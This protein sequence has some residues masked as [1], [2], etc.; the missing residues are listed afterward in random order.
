MKLYLWNIV[1]AADRLLNA[2]FGGTD[3]EYMSSRVYRYK[4]T[5]TA[6][7]FVYTVLNWIEI[8]HCEKAYADCQTGADFSGSD[9]ILK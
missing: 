3:K 2:V 1:Q 7:R 4:D 8:N 5:N 6:A 9:E